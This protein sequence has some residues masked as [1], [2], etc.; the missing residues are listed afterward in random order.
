[1]HDTKELLQDS[2]WVSKI[3]VIQLSVVRI[4]RGKCCHGIVRKRFTQ[5]VGSE[6]SLE[7]WEDF[8]GEKEGEI[9]SRQREGKRIKVKC[10]RERWHLFICSPFVLTAPTCY[11]CLHFSK[12]GLSFP[13]Q[14]ITLPHSRGASYHTWWTCVYSDCMNLCLFLSFLTALWLN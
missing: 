7:G 1:M 10:P 2:W 6:V 5:D 13:S 14:L 11:S 12:P 4:K 8:L 3:L 9:H